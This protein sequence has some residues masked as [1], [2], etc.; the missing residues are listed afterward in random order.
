M[1]DSR[2][3]PSLRQLRVFRTVGQLKSIGRASVLINLSQPAVTQAISNLEAKVGVT[4]FERGH[5]GS[6]LTP[7]GRILLG[8]TERLFDL[9]REALE[10]LLGSQPTETVD[11]DALVGKITTTHIRCLSAVSENVSFDQA[12]RSIGVSQPSLHRVARDFERQIKRA[13]FDRRARG[14]TTTKQGSELARRLKLAMRELDYAFDEISTQR[15]IITSRIA[16]GTLATSGS[17][18]LAR[19]IDEFLAH[20]RGAEVQVVEEPYEQLLS[21]LRAGNIDFLFSVL[22]RPDWATDVTETMLFDEP[23][24]VVMRPKHPLSR[25]M[26]IGRNE[27]ADYDW[28]IP[29]PTTPRYLAFERLF[30]SAKKKPTA[31]VSTTSRGLIRSLLATS[32]RLTLLTRHEAV[33]EEKLGV[34]RIVP[35]RVRLPRRAYG[36]ATRLSWHPTALQQTFLEMLTRH[37]RQAATAYPPTAI[38][39]VS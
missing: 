8:R 30:A 10:N 21:H 2:D 31:R 24:V 14:F 25:V 28:I 4:L 38:A 18:V 6:H 3:Q 11:I 9:I 32:D 22:R 34:L 1:R 5:S 26:D 20:A 36:V 27:L 35:T 16:I 15:G 23:Y 33:L 37:G 39:P 17:F 7:F 19:A 13:I 29:G 12:A